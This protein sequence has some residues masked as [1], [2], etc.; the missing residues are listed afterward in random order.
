MDGCIT[1]SHFFSW[2]SYKVCPTKFW[3][4]PV[5]KKNPWL[6]PV[7]YFG[8]KNK[9]VFLYQ[10]WLYAISNWGLTLTFWITGKTGNL[11]AFVSNCLPFEEQFFR[12]V[13]QRFWGSCDGIYCRHHKS[14][15]MHA[16][17]WASHQ[18]RG[19]RAGALTTG[20]TARSTH[21][22]TDHPS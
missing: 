7:L 14:L 5:G 20:R 9:K 12:P 21:Q 1:F 2:S 13:Q 6:S 10:V 18:H 4:L 16:G 11:P 17:D 8:N 22:A 3:K 15:F 19:G